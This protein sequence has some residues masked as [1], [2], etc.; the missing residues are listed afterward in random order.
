[1]IRRIHP[2]MKAQLNPAIGFVSVRFLTVAPSCH[3]LSGKVLR[4]R[5]IVATGPRLSTSDKQARAALRQLTKVPL[6]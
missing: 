4:R 2:A 6:S 3:R 1:M 5:I